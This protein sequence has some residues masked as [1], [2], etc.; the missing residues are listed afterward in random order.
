[1]TR[2][3]TPRLAKSRHCVKPTAASTRAISNRSE[4]L[5]DCI[6]R[7][8]VYR[9]LQFHKRSQLFIRTQNETLSVVSM[10]VSNPD[11]PSMKIERRYPAHAESGFLEIVSDFTGGDSR[12]L[13]LAEFLEARIAPK[14]IEHRIEAEQRGSKRQA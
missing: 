6:H 9:R 12:L 1:Q 14:R 7:E 2:L 8:F 4:V 10:C 11:C 3:A 5:P 13:F